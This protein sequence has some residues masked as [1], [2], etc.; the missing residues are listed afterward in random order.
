MN[1]ETFNWTRKKSKWHVIIIFFSLAD[2]GEAVKLI[3]YIRLTFPYS[4]DF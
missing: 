1:S 3:A 2:S 4:S